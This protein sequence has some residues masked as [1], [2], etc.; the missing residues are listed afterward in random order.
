MEERSKETAYAA[1]IVGA[2]FLVVW[3]IWKAYA[4]YAPV[5]HTILF[6]SKAIITLPIGVSRWFDLFFAPLYIGAWTWAAQAPVFEGQPG[7]KALVFFFVALVG[8]LAFSA[9]ALAVGA[10][11][12]SVAVCII[13]V[14]HSQALS[15][16]TL[17]TFYLGYGIIRGFLLAACLLAIHAIALVSLLVIA[18]GAQRTVERVSSWPIWQKIAN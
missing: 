3:T 11:I 10:G 13:F 1:F 5:T 14:G 7:D 9:G 16:M 18:H 17:L 4:G 15:L 6:G 2:I 8:G 12:M